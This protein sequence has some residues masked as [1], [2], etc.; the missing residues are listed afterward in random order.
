MNAK[1]LS[2][3]HDFNLIH[4]FWCIYYYCSFYGSFKRPFAVP[5]RWSAAWCGPEGG[6]IVADRAG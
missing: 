4:R 6:R 1:P 3:L 5:D 2:F